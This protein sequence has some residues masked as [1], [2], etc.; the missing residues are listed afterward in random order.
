MDD[1][2][3]AINSNDISK[4]EKL[5]IENKHKVLKYAIESGNYD[6]AYWLQHKFFIPAP[7]DYDRTKVLTSDDGKLWAMN[8]DAITIEDIINYSLDV[9]LLDKYILEEKSVFDKLS[10]ALINV[11]TIDV[12]HLSYLLD[13]IKPQVMDNKLLIHANEKQILTAF[14]RGF[15]IKKI[16]YIKPEW[17][18]IWKEQY[19]IFNKDTDEIKYKKMTMIIL[20]LHISIVKRFI[21]DYKLDQELLTRLILRCNYDSVSNFEYKFYKLCCKTIKNYDEFKTNEFSLQL[22]KKRKSKYFTYDLVFLHK[23]KYYADTTKLSK[24]ASNEY[25]IMYCINNYIDI[26]ADSIYVYI[27]QSKNEDDV[28]NT[29]LELKDTVKFNKIKTTNLLN[30]KNYNK[31]INKIYNI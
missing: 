27:L 18:K 21:V 28:I 22:I 5:K 8:N 4:L 31:T 12:E 11:K 7:L 23:Y 30:Q 20:N 6:I 3:S 2:I 26:S 1:V 19:K 24:F 29:L 9:K 14:K 16:E 13:N 25:I 15:S 17:K 10:N